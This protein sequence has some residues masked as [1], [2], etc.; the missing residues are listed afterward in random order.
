MGYIEDFKSE[1][2]EFRQKTLDFYSGDMKMPAYK[3]YSGKFGSYAQKG[4]KASMLRLRM[5]GGRLTKDR[6]KYIA[7]SIKKHNVD[8]AHFTTCETVQLHNLKPEAIFD[9]MEGGIDHNIITYGGG[10]DFPRN[11]MMSPLSGVDPDENFDVVP[12]VEAAATHLLSKINA[13]MMPRKL[14][15]CFSTGSANVPHATFRDLGF[16]ARKDGLFD[17]YS[18]GGLG[19]NPRFGLLVGEAVDPANILYYIDAMRETFIAYGN[20][21]NRGKARSR[22][23]QETLGEEGYVAAFKEKLTEVLAGDDLTIAVAPISIAK[24]GDGEISD[25]R[26][27]AQKQPGLYAVKYHPLGGNPAPE[28]FGEIYEVIKDMDDVELRISPDESVYIINLTASEA[29]KVLA[30]TND[31][32]KTLFETSVSCV[33]SS[34]CQVGLRDSQGLLMALIDAAREAGI[35]DGALPQIHISG[36]TSSCGTHQTGIMGFNGATKLIDKKPQPAFNFHLGGCD[37]QGKEVMGE[38]IGIMLEKDIPEFI[39]SL[40]RMVQ[41]SG[42][43]FETWF[44]DHKDDV[45]ELAK[46]YI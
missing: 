13:T 40:G 32:A 28:K 39:V 6:L 45:V 21:E 9:I 25:A 2:P 26:V 8:R 42:T 29:E 16:V 7:D 1:L 37:T 20:Y 34:I 3:G 35:K 30:V 31:G 27:I 22:Y 11:I 17:V 12:Y 14:K 10:G 19:N 23:I 24:T 36:C 46:K 4:G 38:Q 15:V 33:G 43:D 18:A 44:A 41:E 5:A